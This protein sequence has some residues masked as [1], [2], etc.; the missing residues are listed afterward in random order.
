MV[1]VIKEISYKGIQ[2][3]LSEGIL[4]NTHNGYA[5]ASGK[6]VGYCKTVNKHYIQ[7]K[8]VEKLNDLIKK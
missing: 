5:N 8:Y 6:H 7:D 4:K 3:L 2:K 1:K